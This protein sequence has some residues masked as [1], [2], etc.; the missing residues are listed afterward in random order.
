MGPFLRVF[1]RGLVVCLSCISGVFTPAVLAQKGEPQPPPPQ[2]L[3]PGKA[4]FFRPSNLPYTD[5]INYQGSLQRFVCVPSGTYQ[6]V[7]TLAYEVGLGGPTSPNATFPGLMLVQ[8][9]A[10]PDPAQLGGLQVFTLAPGIYTGTTN[11]VGA[12]TATV[13]NIGMSSTANEWIVTRGV[14][15]FGQP[16]D[17]LAD[18]PAPATM[19]RAVGTFPNLVAEGWIAQGAYVR[20]PVGVNSL[21]L[22]PPFYLDGTNPNVPGFLTWR[23]ELVSLDVAALGAGG[24]GGGS[25]WATN[26]PPRMPYDDKPRFDSM[27]QTIKDKTLTYVPTNVGGVAPISPSTN[28]LRPE[29]VSLSWV[30]PLS[31]LSG[32]FGSNQNFSDITLAVNMGDYPKL[33]DVLWITRLIIIGLWGTM[34]AGSLFNQLYLK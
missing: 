22:F 32:A 6:W 17:I 26:D 13:I 9:P 1:S 4:C 12:Y 27:T 34:L 30:I 15:T 20:T 23:A 14:R 21:G 18:T 16:G 25:E 28:F 5:L 33:C 31:S 19:L 29:P 3:P 7:Y 10:L 2:T 8:G 24:S 11:V